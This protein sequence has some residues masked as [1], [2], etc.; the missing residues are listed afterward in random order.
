MS[1]NAT[2]SVSAVESVSQ[3]LQGSLTFLVPFSMK[4]LLFA[5]FLFMFSTSPNLIKLFSLTPTNT[6]LNTPKIKQ[7]RAQ[8]KKC[9]RAIREYL[10]VPWVGTK[11]G[12]RTMVMPMGTIGRRPIPSLAWSRRTANTHTHM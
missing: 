5:E 8:G 11:R 12:T 2:A 1:Y 7:V 6:Q 10:L 9:G 4:C 3:S